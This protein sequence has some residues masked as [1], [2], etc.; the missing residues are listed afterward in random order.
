MSHFKLFFEASSW[1]K[2]SQHNQITWRRWLT[3]S[4][5]KALLAA[6]FFLFRFITHSPAKSGIDSKTYEINTYIDIQFQSQW[7]KTSYE[8]FLL[9]GVTKKELIF[10]MLHVI[11]IWFKVIGNPHHCNKPLTLRAIHRGLL[12]LKKVEKEWHGWHYSSIVALVLEVIDEGL[13]HR[14]QLRGGWGNH[15]MVQDFNFEIIERKLDALNRKDAFIKKNGTN[16]IY[17]LQIL[18]SSLGIN[19]P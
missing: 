4:S 14:V 11:R 9:K 16:L 2:V 8:P 15:Q 7:Q 6:G 19:T 12:Y 17:L 10:K 3:V 5:S 13:T 1:G 18:L